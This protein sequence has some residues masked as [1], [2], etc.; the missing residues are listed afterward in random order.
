MASISHGEHQLVGRQLLGA[1]T[2]AVAQ[3]FMDQGL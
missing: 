2:E 1:T 3:Q